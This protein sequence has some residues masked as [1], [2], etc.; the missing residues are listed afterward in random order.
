MVEQADLEVQGPGQPADVEGVEGAQQGAEGG[1]H[2]P[3]VIACC[4]LIT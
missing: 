3:R 2:L 1:G 4:T